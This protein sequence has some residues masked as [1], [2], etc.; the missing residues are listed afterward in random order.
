[1][2]REMRKKYAPVPDSA[3]R[4]RRPAGGKD[5]IYLCGVIDELESI[6]RDIQGNLPLNTQHW[7]NQRLLIARAKK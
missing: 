1:M 6:V 5:V 7:I 3:G 4:M 2:T